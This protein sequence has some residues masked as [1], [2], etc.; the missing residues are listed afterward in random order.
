MST[1]H[2]VDAQGIYLGGFGDGAVPPQGAVEVGAPPHGSATWN[3][4][5]WIMPPQPVPSSVPAIKLMRACQRIVLDRTDPQNP[6]WRNANAGETRS[7]PAVRA[8]MWGA[9][10]NG[11]ANGREEWEKITDVPRAA[12]EW[13]YLDAGVRTLMPDQMR[14]DAFLDYIFLKALTV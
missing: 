2:Y 10:W 5:A 3:G 9:T 6:I 14:T 11:D 12:A 7:W 4:S 13:G 1:I 8:A